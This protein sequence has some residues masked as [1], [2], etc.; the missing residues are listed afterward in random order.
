VTS[1]LRLPFDGPP[2]PDPM[3]RDQAARRFAVDPRQNVVLEASAGTGKTR[4]LVDRYVNLI[5]AGVAPA[6]ILAITFTRKAAAEMRE[7]IIASLRQ[8]S[9]LSEAHAARW[10]A[11]RDHLAD[12]AISTIDAFCLQLLRE[13]PLEADLDPGFDVA[14]ETDVLRA[15]DEALD[16]T[17]GVSRRLAA[18]SADVAL[19]FAQ[20]DERRLRAGLA[21]LLERRLVVGRALGRFLAAAPAAVTV[22]TA[23]RSAADA[24]AGCVAGISDGLEGF[25]ANGPDDPQFALVAR[26]LGALVAT[27]GDDSAAAGESLEATIDTLRRYFTTTAGTPRKRLPTRLVRGLFQSP[28][29]RQRHAADVAQLGGDIERIIAAFRR[30]L[31]GVVARGVWRM[32]QI[33]R[34]QYRRQLEEAGVL[35]FTGLLARALTLLARMDEF[36]QSRYRLESR[37]HHL[38]VDEFQDTSSA[39]WRLVR[40]LVQSWGE[41]QGLPHD[42]LLQPSIFVVGDRKQSIYGFRDADVTILGRA[43]RAIERLRPSGRV[44]RSI[45]KSFRSGPALL[46]FANDLFSAVEQA[47][48]RR[49]RFRF[50]PR[51]HFPIES[52]GTA[53]D[54]PLGLVIADDMRACAAA[55]AAEIGR[56]LSEGTVRDRATGLPRSARPGDVAVL[57]RSRESHRA[58]TEA[59]DARG[60]PSYVYKGLGFF[61]ADEVKDLVALVGYLGNPTSDLRA[62]AFL[63]S[64]FVRLSDPALHVLAG[65]LAS[66]LSSPTPPPQLS[67]L[68]AD[69]QQ[70]LQRIREAVAGWLRLADRLPPASLLDRVLADTAYAWELRGAR[71]SQARENLKKMR[72]IVRR[73][74]NRGYATLRRIADHLEQLSTGDE[75]NAIV[76]AVDAVNLMTVHAAKG[77]EFPLVFLVNVTRGTGGRRPPIRVVASAARGRGDLAQVS[78]SVGDFVS[79]ADEDLKSRDREETKRLL[80]VAVTRARERLYLSAVLKNARLQPGQGSLAEVLPRSFCD[81]MREARIEDVERE[82]EWVAPGGRVHRLRVLPVAPVADVHPQAGAGHLAEPSIDVFGPVEDQQRVERLTVT[83]YISSAAANRVPL[84]PAFEDAQRERRGD[85]GR[86]RAEEEQ[87]LGTVVHR[88]FQACRGALPAEASDLKARAHALIRREERTRIEDEQVF[89]DRVAEACG[90]LARRPEL[91]EILGHAELLYEVPFSLR[92]AGRQILRGAMDCVARHP[93]GTITIVEFKT[94]KPGPEH[95]AQLALYVEAALALFP[96]R[97]IERLLLYADVPNPEG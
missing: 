89:L 87:L 31:N 52:P 68:P 64:R 14:D 42:A 1:N 65:R 84:G 47:E 81:V 86:G 57:F 80:Y 90:A 24:L 78:V 44:R 38:L 95:D 67:E 36:S 27:G 3:A 94:G 71:L 29:A 74:Q 17:L 97:P 13:F 39:Q 6:N 12:V 34:H 40:L 32:F 62:A 61:D 93:D 7:R 69:D 18:T 26:D 22:E 11:L 79:E 45:A 20:L 8:Q 23:R 54:V 60:I 83:R 58:F 48:N 85:R 21:A 76:D 35:D 53:G 30:D 72:A 41:G 77:L 55:V 92:T 37:Y 59:L 25:L 4:V 75:S 50:G 70:V 88:V 33:A 10:R 51:D 82:T 19:V 46:A 28:H 43:R 49:D 2:G 96:G 9:T 15:M 56:V 5:E 66:A 91:E 63:R 73:I 16:R